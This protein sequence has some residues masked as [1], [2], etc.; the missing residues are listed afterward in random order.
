MLD[1]TLESLP[2]F[3]EVQD[4]NNPESPVTQVSS[5]GF[6]RYAAKPGFKLKNKIADVSRNAKDEDIAFATHQYGIERQRMLDEA[7]QQFQAQTQSLEDVLR[8]PPPKPVKAQLSQGQQ[9]AGGIAAL[10]APNLAGDI[11]T[12]LMGRAHEEADKA[13]EQQL[14]EWKFSQANAMRELKTAEDIRNFRLETQMHLLDQ[15]FKLKLDAINQ[16]VQGKSKAKADVAEAWQTGNVAQ[17]NFAMQELAHDLSPEEIEDMDKSF[18]ERVE[19][20]KA[21]EESKRRHEVAV[22]ENIATDNAERSWRPIISGITKN[23]VD[24]TVEDIARLNDERNKIAVAHGVDPGKLTPVDT[25]LQAGAKSKYELSVINSRIAQARLEEYVKSGR[26]NR[27]ETPEAWAVFERMKALE[28]SNA[29]EL[30]GTASWGDI[31]DPNKRAE[32]LPKAIKDI[33]ALIDSTRKGKVDADT[34]K[35]VI[36]LRE[37]AKLDGVVGDIARQALAMYENAWGSKLAALEDQL[38]KAKS[39]LGTGNSNVGGGNVDPLEAEALRRGF[40]K[41]ANGKWY[42]PKG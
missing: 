18:N 28:L 41:D 36:T 10:I 11:T 31:N 4:P 29:K 5:Y 1:G 34:S 26:F 6:E 25:I 17:Y 20:I 15:E 22:T 35:E 23:P 19:H 2:A 33:Q 32:K 13:T 3:G 7:I 8:T 27:K 37:S 21:L 12:H 40:K 30:K 42:K 9:I 16:K 38:E 14:N 39:A 24:M